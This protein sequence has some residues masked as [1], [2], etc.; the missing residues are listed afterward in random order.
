MP[1]SGQRAPVLP[2]AGERGGEGFAT[3]LAGV[4]LAGGQSRR[5]GQDKALL[6][7]GAQGRVSLL[8]RA[9]DSLRAICS[10]VWI[11]CAA[12]R[13]HAGFDCVEDEP[14][15]PVVRAEGRHDAGP[16]LG[17]ITCLARA[18][19]EGRQGVLVLP[20]D[21]PLLPERLL[22]DLI[23]GAAQH[24]TA[25]AV[26]Y[27]TP[28]GWEEPL[29]GV[30]RCGALPALRE[31]LLAG[32]CRV[33]AALPPEGKHLL[34]LSEAEHGLFANCNTPEQARALGVRAPSASEPG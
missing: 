29:V 13:R 4:V 11:S 24:P 30:Y 19:R 31:A 8:R 21:M 22:R 25:L 32:Q 2:Q 3:A 10:E 17:I 15:P 9:A 7:C 14:L 5:M 16:L 20:C 26:Y 33:R 1:L 12:G 18:A 23:N 27:R 34:P 6:C 28:G